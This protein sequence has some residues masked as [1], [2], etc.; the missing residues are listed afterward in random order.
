MAYKAQVMPGNS[1]N[2]RANMQIYKLNCVGESIQ[3][4]PCAVM[5]E[6]GEIGK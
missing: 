1:G 5:E 4:H 6:G 3:K 2:L